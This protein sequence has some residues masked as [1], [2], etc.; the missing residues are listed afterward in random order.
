MMSPGA[1][2]KIRAKTSLLFNTGS[3]CLTLYGS[4]AVI[5]TSS[6]QLSNRYQPA[7]CVT[8]WRCPL[9]VIIGH[10]LS[11]TNVRFTRKQTSLKATGMSAFC[12]KQTSSE[13]RRP[14]RLFHTTLFE[15]LLIEDAFLIGKYEIPFG[16]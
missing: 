11:L 16:D 2:V 15:P 4:A 3:T 7:A 5:M 13:S 10:S 12:Q 8:L 1:S 6:P 9:W 14:P